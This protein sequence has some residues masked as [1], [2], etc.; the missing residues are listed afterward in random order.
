MHNYLELFLE[1]LKSERNV[2]KNTVES[3]FSDLQDFL[4]HVDINVEITE[5]KVAGYLEI[6]K[7]KNFQ[8]STIKRKVSALKQ[9]FRFLVAEKEKTDEGRERS[10]P[11]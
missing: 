10:L 2:S 9:F 3:Y 6:L 5:E 4:A 11:L 7:N 1:Y 8:V